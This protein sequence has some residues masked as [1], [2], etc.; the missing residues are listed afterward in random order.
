MSPAQFHFSSL[1][2]SS[3]HF[4]SLH[5][6]HLTSQADR[7]FQTSQWAR[8]REQYSEL[9]RIA[10]LSTTVILNRAWTMFRMGDWYE[11]IADTGKVL[12]IESNNLMALELRGTCYYILGEFEMSQ[13]HYRQALKL[14]PEHAGCKAGHKLIKKILKAK[15]KFSKA[16]DSGKNEDALKYLQE[17]I[18]SDQEHPVTVPEANKDMAR[19]YKAMGRF[20]DA[21]GVAEKALKA[22]ENNLDMIRLMG[23]VHMAADEFD[24]AGRFV[25]QVF[26]TLESLFVLIYLLFNV[27][28]V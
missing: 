24:E 13:N 28:I 6:P 12:K 8:A 1:H 2:F 15:D 23:E 19:I 11:S 27:S 16:R 20:K 7:N 14:D 18:D 10:D 9:L 26:V 21:K 5:S 3:L 25:Y 4:S 17:I 22:D